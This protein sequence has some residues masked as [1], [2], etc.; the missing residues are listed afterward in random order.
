MFIDLL[1]LEYQE[2]EEAEMSEL[3]ELLSNM[4]TLES[5]GFEEFEQ[6]TVVIQIVEIQ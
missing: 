2:V 5:L 1:S 3:D 4:V 6:P